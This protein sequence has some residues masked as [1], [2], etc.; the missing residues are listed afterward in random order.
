MEFSER[1]RALREDK[2]MSAAQLAG[3]FNKSEG[4]VRMWETGRSKPDA[5]TLIKLA[6]FFGCTTDYLLGVSAHKSVSEG[7]QLEKNLK[8]LGDALSGKSNSEDLIAALT[9]L[10]NVKEFPGP[11]SY[12]VVL[13]I[14]MSINLMLMRARYFIDTA[15]AKEEIV[16]S[17][18][19]PLMQLMSTYPPVLMSMVFEYKKVIGHA[20][21]PIIERFGTS[22]H[23]K[24]FDMIFM[25]QNITTK[26]W[27]DDISTYTEEILEMRGGLENKKGK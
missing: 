12:S 22:D 25:H 11:E 16:P 20:I 8:L 27:R 13:A 26:E 2:K 9:I 19:D 21:S 3:A 6:E 7:Q 17:A 24:K 5:D 1:L 23:R 4:A 18:F 15:C 14:D 10:G